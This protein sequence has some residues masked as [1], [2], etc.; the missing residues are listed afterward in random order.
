MVDTASGSAAGAVG[1]GGAAMAAIGRGA[2][3]QLASETAANVA[4]TRRRRRT[5]V[6]WQTVFA[7]R[8]TL[9]VLVALAVSPSCSRADPPASY[10]TSTVVI[11]APVTTVA[12]PP[13]PT[14]TVLPRTST[15]AVVV[16][17]GNPAR[18][19]VA[20]TFDAGSDVGFARQILDTLAAA[21]VTA[22]FGLTGRW[23]EENPDLVRRVAAGGHQLVNHTY[24][25][26][27]FTGVSA[28]PAVTSAAAR[29]DQ[30]ARADDILAG[31]SGATTRPWFRPPYG[32]Y[33]PSVNADVGA[34]GYGYNVLWTVDSL[35]WQGLSASAIT[36][37]CLAGAQPGAIYLF[38]VGS[39][40][41]DAAALPAVIAGLRDQGYSFGTVAQL[42]AD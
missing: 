14:T 24:D 4:A 33:N 3:V 29:H 9:P 31:L 27:S 39:A 25:H 26:R 21:G 10:P 12:S 5:L 41:Q 16:A 7:P 37:R 17:R 2:W 8:R 22:T 35:G 36:A 1:R 28:Q 18:R 40:S 15:P 19:M 30:L 32:D 6:V 23:A 42:L 13:A 38:H 20:L 34:I 11:T